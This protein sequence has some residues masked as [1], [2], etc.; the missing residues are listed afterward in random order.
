VTGAHINLAG[1]TEIAIGIMVITGNSKAP[2]II[3]LIIFLRI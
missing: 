3:F 2:R 1:V